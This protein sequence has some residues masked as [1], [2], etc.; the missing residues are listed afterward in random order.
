M[1]KEKESSILGGD[2]HSINPGDLL[3]LFS[4]F[5]F[6]CRALKQGKGVPKVAGIQQ[7]QVGN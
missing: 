5:P 6:Q 2:V 3:V 1:T 7:S 4:A